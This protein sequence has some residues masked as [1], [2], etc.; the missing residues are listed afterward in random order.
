MMASEKMLPG[1]LV[2]RKEHYTV[3]SRNLTSNHEKREPDRTDGMAYGF[4]AHDPSG[5]AVGE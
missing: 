3:R 2:S 1:S 5:G 4:D